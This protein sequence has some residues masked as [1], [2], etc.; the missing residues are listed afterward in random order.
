M[1]KAWLVKFQREAKTLPGYLCE[2]SSVSSQQEYLNQLCLQEIGNQGNHE[3][4]LLEAFPNSTQRPALFLVLAA[5][6][7]NV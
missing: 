3:V 7:G 4:H 1:T 2:E 6:S 5:K